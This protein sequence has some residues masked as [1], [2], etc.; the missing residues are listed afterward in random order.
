MKHSVGERLGS[1]DETKERE[2]M[3]PVVRPLFFFADGYY[4]EFF[5]VLYLVS[6]N[7]VPLLL[8]S[9]RY[10]LMGSLD[11]GG[12]PADKMSGRRRVRASSHTDSFTLSAFC[13]SS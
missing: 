6:W 4:Y 12:D 1:K 13:F 5:L 10:L 2:T 11:V 3:M 8:M 7:F 9:L